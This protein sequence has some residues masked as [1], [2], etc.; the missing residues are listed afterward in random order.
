MCKDL[1]IDV[2]PTWIIQVD[3]SISRSADEQHNSICN[4][5]FP[6][7]SNRTK[8]WFPG[9]RT[10]TSLWAGWG[11]VGVIIL[12]TTFSISAASLSSFPNTVSSLPAL[13]PHGPLCFPGKDQ[14]CQASSHPGPLYP[15]F[16]WP[17][18]LARGAKAAP[19][20]FLHRDCPDFSV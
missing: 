1:Y 14:T 12:P 18:V 6:L 15:L 10:W 2:R 3:L 7:A 11:G 20:G 4:L 9:I 17:R 8:W 19:A 13:P 16:P 5:N